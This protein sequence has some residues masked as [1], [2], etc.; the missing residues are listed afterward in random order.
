MHRCT[1]VFIW[2]ATPSSSFV[3]RTIGE[4]KLNLRVLTIY[5][6][7]SHVHTRGIPISGNFAHRIV[8]G[9][10]GFPGNYRILLDSF[11]FWYI[12]LLGINEPYPK[13]L[14]DNFNTL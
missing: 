2:I 11:K 1:H 7:N 10:K 9:K 14:V 12:V 8:D 13:C 6:D 4:C 5:R 3:S